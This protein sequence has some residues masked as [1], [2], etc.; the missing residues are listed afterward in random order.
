MKAE[1]INK[2]I[3]ELSG[4]GKFS[5][6]W[7]SG[8]SDFVVDW[9]D[10]ENEAPTKE[11]VL[12]RYDEL[13]LQKE[14]LKFVANNSFEID[15]EKAFDKYYIFNLSGFATIGSLGDIEQI[16]YKTNND[17]LAIVETRENVRS[18]NGLVKTISQTISVKYYRKDGTYLENVLPTRLLSEYERTELDRKARANTVNKIKTDLIKQLAENT[19]PEEL[20]TARNEV[21]GMFYSLSAQISAYEQSVISPLIQSLGAYPV[22]THVTTDLIASM[23]GS[24]DYL[25]YE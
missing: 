15:F 23:T 1:L 9:Q 5:L 24:L 22:N 21:G 2:A 8:F 19:A 18:V 14:G 7:E 25:L 6:I 16:Q 20:E 3:L 13:E 4:T 11:A 12:T 17:E 10:D